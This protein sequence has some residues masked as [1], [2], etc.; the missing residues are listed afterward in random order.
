MN[1]TNPELNDFFNNAKMWKNELMRLREVL[2]SFG[3]TEELKWKQP[4][5]GKEGKNIVIIGALNNCATIGFF[6]GALIKDPKHILIQ[7]TENTLSARIIKFTSVDYI[8]DIKE[9]LRDFVN[10]AIEVEKKGLKADFSKNKVI[11]IPI[12]L[13]KIFDEDPNFKDAFYA[14]TKGRQKGY[15]LHFSSAKK[16]ATQIARIEKYRQKIF[17]GLGMNDY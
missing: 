14:L 3:L 7:Q 5:Y 6:K 8:N 16:P 13:Q 4:C 11:N 9:D 1:K 10:Q 2:I 12:Q 17:D 15:I